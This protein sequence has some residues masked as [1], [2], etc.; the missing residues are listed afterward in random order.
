MK[1]ILR[2]DQLKLKRS[3]ILIIVLLIP[4][5]ILTYE[6]VNFTYRAEL[7]DKQAELFH[8]GS[9]WM[10]LLYDNSLLFG[11]GFP[12]AATL[13]ASIIANIEH[14][15]DGWKQLLAFPV[16]RSKVYLSK[17]IWLTMSLLISLTIFLI[18]MILLGKA[19]EFEESVPLGL[20]AGDSY[21]MLIATLP[22]TAFQLWLSMTIK[23]Q[24]FPILIGAICTIMGLFLAAVQMTRWFPLAYPIQS[25]TV[26]L[27]YEG[28]GYNT[29]LPVYLAINLM[30]GIALLCMG[31]IHFVKRDNQ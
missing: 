15:A 5:L 13:A 6:L 22:F 3:S 11:L 24:A 27:Q 2:A 21:G 23:N 8:A 30:L 18:G 17:F 25:S 31:V 16:S 12:L 14:Q 10:Y 19:L 7:V 26:I 20:L 9:M 1:E 4:I 28:I 29:D